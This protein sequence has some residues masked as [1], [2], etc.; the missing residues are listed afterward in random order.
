MQV[1]FGTVFLW[2]PPNVSNVPILPQI[3]HGPEE[4]SKNL[5]GS[6]TYIKVFSRAALSRSMLPL[7]SLSTY[8][9]AV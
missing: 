2:A 7:K 3:T 9:A 5:P 8:L 4:E 1:L 6:I